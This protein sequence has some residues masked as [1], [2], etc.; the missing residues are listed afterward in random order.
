MKTPEKNSKGGRSV[1]HSAFYFSLRS[2]RDPSWHI[3]FQKFGHL[4]TAVLLA[5][6]EYMSQAKHFQLKLDS[7]FFSILYRD[8]QIEK[9]KFNEIIQYCIAEVGLYDNYLF[10]AGSLFS[11]DL[12]RNF[13]N[14]GYFRNRKF[15]AN[16]ILSA[17]NFLRKG[18][19]P[20]SLEDDFEQIMQSVASDTSIECDE[21]DQPT[22]SF[23]HKIPNQ[24]QD[25]DLPF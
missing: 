8:H 14:S 3:V 13:H 1:D 9:D 21:E 7:K 10:E 15:K 18:Q 5:N 20:L 12:L 16:D 11:L 2:Q 4:G 17:I 24:D 19:K 22:A 23:Q 25:S 6:C